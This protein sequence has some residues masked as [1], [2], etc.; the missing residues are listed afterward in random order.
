L[1][2]LQ[3]TNT[4][5]KQSS[6]QSHSNNIY[7]KPGSE[8]YSQLLVRI[9]QILDEITLTSYYFIDSILNETYNIVY[10]HLNDEF[11]LVYM[12]SLWVTQKNVENVKYIVDV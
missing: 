7:N 6:V 12:H 10:M 3:Y 1:S 9:M 5:Q 4:L 2:L 8:V 11:G